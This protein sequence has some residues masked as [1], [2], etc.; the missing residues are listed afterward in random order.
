MEF[1]FACAEINFE[2]LKMAGLNLIGL[3][4]TLHVC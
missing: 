2:E 3:N 4:A 1:G